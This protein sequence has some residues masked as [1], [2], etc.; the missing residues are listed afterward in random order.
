M[1]HRQLGSLAGAAHLLNYNACVLRVAQRGQKS[2]VDQM[3]NAYFIVIFSI[4]TNCENTA[5]RSFRFERF[6]IRGVRKVTTG[7]TGLW[8]PSVRS[9]VAF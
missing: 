2:D 8:Q 9:D 3:G 1:I 5:Y 7:I 6:P 4:N